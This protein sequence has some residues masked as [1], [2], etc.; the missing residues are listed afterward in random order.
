MISSML[1]ISSCLIVLFALS[2]LVNSQKISVTNISVALT[3]ITITLGLFSWFNFQILKEQGLYIF[4]G[5][6]LTLVY[7]ILKHRP[8]IEMGGITLS[9]AVFIYLTVFAYKFLPEYRFHTNLDPIYYA[10]NAGFIKRH[11]S[12]LAGLRSSENY[13]GVKYSLSK[14]PSDDG[15]WGKILNLFKIPEF[16]DRV[17]LINVSSFHDG[18]TYFGLLST[19]FKKD[20]QMFFQIWQIIMIITVSLILGITYKII[21]TIFDKAIV[22]KQRFLLYIL[23][24]TAFFQ[25]FT[26]VSNFTE[27]FLP[28][29][30]GILFVLTFG[31]ILLQIVKQ[32]VALNESIIKLVLLF[33]ATL[34]TYAQ[35]LLLLFFFLFLT[36]CYLTIQKKLSKLLTTV[37]TLGI[38]SASLFIPFIRFFLTQILQG[39]NAANTSFG[40]FN[41]IRN[42]EPLS[43]KS[44][45]FIKTTD[46]EISYQG[47]NQTLSGQR[48]F[49]GTVLLQS[50]HQIFVDNINLTVI[51]IIYMIF[52]LLFL[53]VNNKENYGYGFF[54]IPTLIIYLLM[55]FYVINHL[56]VTSEQNT[57]SA[58]IWYRLNSILV[59]FNVIII[60]AFVFGRYFA[61]VSHNRAP[62]I[63]LAL[64]FCF[65]IY[66]NQTYY[67]NYKNNSIKAY[68]TEKCP[69]DN[70]INIYYIG[71]VIPTASIGFCGHPLFFL[72]GGTQ[73]SVKPGNLIYRF[74]FDETERNYRQIFLGRFEINE[75]LIIPNNC[76][77]NCVLAFKQFKTASE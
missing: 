6:I 2:L 52:A 18:G 77:V 76:G 43:L 7:K 13:T 21:S 32:Q 62:G 11:G 68:T 27:G 17:G 23:V 20:L 73:V 71:D 67:S 45:E 10:N 63:I 50:G 65:T 42:F 70:G 19:F 53:F 59:I 75:E 35:Y 33:F 26:F 37:L 64:V 9:C 1:F 55:L 58:Y 46:S 40:F 24:F 61:A 34:L 44:I 29:T 60:I 22:P 49:N 54:I 28:Q 38:I 39:T 36:L 16:T 31:L 8:K 66:S 15:Q 51:C 69:S 57:F 41:P 30:L 47:L 74:Q 14:I 4:L 48:E 25:S 12:I 56:L 3:I 72:N 5:L